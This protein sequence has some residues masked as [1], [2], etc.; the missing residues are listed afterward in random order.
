MLTWV[1]NL[2]RWCLLTEEHHMK[3]I[4]LVLAF[5]LILCGCTT[6]YRVTDLTTDN[7]YYTTQ[8]NKK[9]SGAVHFKD[10]R[11]GSKVTL[12]SS[13]ITKIT[14]EEFTYGDEKE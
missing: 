3:R 6:Y 2:T 8:I 9:G 11:S 12:Q 1:H 14:K 4:W 5:C 13:K 10:S 7:S